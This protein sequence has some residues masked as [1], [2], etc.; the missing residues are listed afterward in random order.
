MHITGLAKDQNGTKFYKAKNSWG[1]QSSKYGGYVYMSKFYARS[2]TVSVILHKDG[3][4]PKIA[5]LLKK[6]QSS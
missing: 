6:N 1:I 2:K 3:L 5:E 4:P